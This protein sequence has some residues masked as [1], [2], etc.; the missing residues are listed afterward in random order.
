MRREYFVVIFQGLFILLI[1][2]FLWLSIVLFGKF[3]SVSVKTER[4]VIVQNFNI[5][6]F[7]I[8]IV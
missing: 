6:A 7:Y 4:S 2:D 1:F 8:M 3:M 5:Y